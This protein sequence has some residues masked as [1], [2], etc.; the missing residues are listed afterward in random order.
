M[1]DVL[2]KTNMNE[3]PQ[4]KYKLYKLEIS[5]SFVL[6]NYE[7]VTPIEKSRDQRLNRD[8]DVWRM[9]LG[10]KM[11]SVRA[12]WMSMLSQS[13]RSSGERDRESIKEKDVKL[14]APR[15]PPEN[16]LHPS[17][18]SNSHSSPVTMETSRY[19]QED[20][21]TAVDG[22]VAV[23]SDTFVQRNPLCRLVWKYNSIKELNEG[24][25]LEESLFLNKV[26]K[27]LEEIISAVITKNEKKYAI[28]P[29]CFK[30]FS[31]EKNT[32][33]LIRIQKS[34]C[35][36]RE[37]LRK[38]FSRTWMFP[39]GQMSSQDQIAVALVG[40]RYSDI[41]KGAILS[42]GSDQTLSVSQSDERRLAV[43]KPVLSA[44]AARGRNYHRLASD[45]LCQHRCFR[46]T[47]A[48]HNLRYH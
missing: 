46:V 22:R 1:T 48:L 14:R 27:L 3:P 30:D 43:I 13:E 39:A 29:V 12:D 5:E 24:I 7:D 17:Q 10:G 45:C 9:K 41:R 28:F 21:A 40:N 4:W 31:L 25:K 35:G 19:F 42:S 16:R 32:T 18:E 38:R 34:V 37:T 20:T 8:C 44:R 6:F 36:H 15:G 11:L 33:N 47:L 2:P 26:L 23:L